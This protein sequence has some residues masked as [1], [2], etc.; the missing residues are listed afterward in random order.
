[1]DAA[2]RSTRAD[3]TNTMPSWAI[4]RP[5]NSSRLVA[6]ANTNAGDEAMTEAVRAVI[7]RPPHIHPYT[8][9]RNA[10]TRSSAGSDAL[11]GRSG[12]ISKGAMGYLLES[13]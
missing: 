11:N 12:V 8:E 2:S 3:S 9:R 13:V 1:M 4:I 5:Q 7:A 10:L 6:T